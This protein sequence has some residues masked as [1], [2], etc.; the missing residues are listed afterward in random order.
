MSGGGVGGHM[1][2]RC[3]PAHGQHFSTILGAVSCDV[4]LGS[5][6]HACSH[7][8]GRYDLVGGLNGSAVRPMSWVKSVRSLFKNLS[9]SEPRSLCSCLAQHTSFR[10][11]RS[12]ELWQCLLACW[13][14]PADQYLKSA[15]MPFTWMYRHHQHRRPDATIQT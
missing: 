15:C 5:G 3:S 13:I 10:C 6:A 4:D 7:P 1:A 8:S 9:S 12:A 2:A 11:W 14:Q